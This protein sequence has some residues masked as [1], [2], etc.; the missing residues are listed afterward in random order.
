[1]IDGKPQNIG[2]LARIAREHRGLTQRELAAKVGLAQ[3]TIAELEAPNRRQVPNIH[4]FLHVMQTLD[5]AVDVTITPKEN[6]PESWNYHSE[7]YD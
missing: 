7:K 3:S 1:M 4:T 6:K 5:F 2:D